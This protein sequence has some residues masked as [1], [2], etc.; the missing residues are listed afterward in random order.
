MAKTIEA[1]VR[2]AGTSTSE[3]RVRDHS[4]LIDRPEAK[5]GEDRGAM[6]GELLLLS[7]G[8]CFMSTLLAA[9]RARETPLSDATLLVSATI[10]G[11]PERMTAFGLT[12]RASGVG[13][14]ELE[15]LALVAERGCLVSNTLA[16]AAPV[17]VRVEAV[18]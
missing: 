9:A 12:L 5:G 6:G 17:E 16:P 1:T 7:L 10:D 11:T 14:D 3:G 15:K 18:E 8:G 4:V 13:A 2:Q